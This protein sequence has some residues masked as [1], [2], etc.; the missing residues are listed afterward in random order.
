[1]L[2]SQDLEHGGPNA[3]K[4]SAI[5]YKNSKYSNHG[6]VNFQDFL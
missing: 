2:E 5:M 4:N 6:V 3:L 1:M